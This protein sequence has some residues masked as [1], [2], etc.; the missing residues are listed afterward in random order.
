MSGR[1]AVEVSRAYMNLFHRMPREISEYTHNARRYCD[2][3]DHPCEGYYKDGDIFKKIAGNQYWDKKSF[4][5]KWIAEDVRKGNLSK[6]EAL[7][8]LSGYIIS[9]EGFRSIFGK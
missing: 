6:R 5:E 8:R 7:W 9:E 3:S 4:R 1:A 2:H